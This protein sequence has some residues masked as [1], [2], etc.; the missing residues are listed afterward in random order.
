MVLK[1]AS[2]TGVSAWD[3]VSIRAGMF[4]KKEV[5]CVLRLLL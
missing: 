2:A 4:A 1:A 3:V 5:R